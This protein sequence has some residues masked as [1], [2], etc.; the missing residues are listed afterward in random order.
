[1]AY[2]N[3]DISDILIAGI[4]KAADKLDLTSALGTDILTKGRNSNVTQDPLTGK[5][6]ISSNGSLHNAMKDSSEQSITE[7]LE[8]KKQNLLKQMNP[9]KKVRDN[10][11]AKVVYNEVY[12]ANQQL[13]GMNFL[14]SNYDF[15]NQIDDIYYDKA[16][17][18]VNS[19]DLNKKVL[20][21]SDDLDHD[22]ANGII[23]TN[24]FIL[25][26]KALDKTLHL[27]YKNSDLALNIA[28]LK[29]EVFKNN[30]SQAD[31]QDTDHLMSLASSSN[32]HDTLKNTEHSS[33]TNSSN[34]T[35]NKI[36]PNELIKQRDNKLISDMTA[37][38]IP[39]SN[40]TATLITKGNYKAAAE[41]HV[42][43][44][45]KAGVKPN[46]KVI[47][48]L[49]DHEHV[50]EMNKALVPKQT[51]AQ[52]EAVEQNNS[53]PKDFEN[54]L[55]PANANNE[56]IDELVNKKGSN[57][58]IDGLANNGSNN[59]SIDSVMGVQQPTEEQP[60]VDQ[61]KTQ[62]PQIMAT[63]TPKEQLQASE[64]TKE[65][66][67]NIWD[68]GNA[69]LLNK[70]EVDKGSKLNGPVRDKILKGHLTSSIKTLQGYL[71][72][73][74]VK[75]PTSRARIKNLIKGLKGQVKEYKGI[76]SMPKTKPL[77]PED[78]PIT[79]NTKT[80][81][82]EPIKT[83]T[84]VNLHYDNKD[85]STNSTTRRILK[86]TK[87]TTKDLNNVKKDKDGYGIVGTY[88]GKKIYLDNNNNIIAK[89][90]P[91]SSVVITGKDADAARKKIGTR[92]FAA[93]RYQIIPTTL[94]A[95][96]KAANVSLDAKFNK[97]NQDKLFNYR[98]STVGG[99]S[100][101]IKH[102]KATLRQKQSIMLALARTWASM[103]V[104][105]SV[106]DKKGKLH[107]RGYSYY[108]G[109]ANKAGHSYEKTFAVLDRA[110]SSGK[111]D[112]LRKLIVSGESGSYNTFNQ[113]TIG[114][115]LIPANKKID[116]SKF[117]IREI[118]S[119][120]THDVVLGRKR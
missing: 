54:G 33:A 22:Y 68:K 34:G 106:K 45:K 72:K 115:E 107:K 76:Q 18:K 67:T 79:T 73:N 90:N 35:S 41:S 40:E 5:I 27:H 10:N 36:I 77:H 60:T 81:V 11:L 118:L 21:V 62:M 31:A 59:E 9:N 43:D 47:Q 42:E 97:E 48:T 38:N 108:S 114:K 95:W 99:L 8:R 87:F 14:E 4:E 105:Y 30:A 6:G 49:K 12:E 91:G 3:L 96:S 28:S 66:R 89:A 46:E 93:G 88:H 82:A 92:I 37:N 44:A 110:I 85:Y 61:I 58:S 70:Y 103:P 74:Q 63:D 55:I 69:D 50:T 101:A 53:E 117:T 116:L 57:E 65:Q 100:S 80:K 112:E 119:S 23:D 111:M 64:L 15:S 16:K 84:N 24:E 75:N 78:A 19:S 120:S 39:V 83:N 20:K 25:G 32:V 94:K 109:G 71:D 26:K 56:S 17:T 104:P 86:Y 29:D 1:M 13:H 113:G 51:K 2:S 102:K 7:S 52:Q 98:L